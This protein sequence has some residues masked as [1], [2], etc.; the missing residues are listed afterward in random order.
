MTESNS[1]VVMTHGTS[2]GGSKRYA[3]V[4][5]NGYI[6]LQ[7]ERPSIERS[8]SKGCFYVDVKLHCRNVQSRV[9]EDFPFQPSPDGVEFKEW[10][11]LKWSTDGKRKVAY[12]RAVI[13]GNPMSR[14]GWEEA[15]AYIVA[16]KVGGKLADGLKTMAHAGGATWEGDWEAIADYFQGLIEKEME[17]IRPPEVKPTEMLLAAANMKFGVFAEKAIIVAALNASPVNEAADVEG[18]DADDNTFLADDDEEVF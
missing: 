14:N 5:A 12:A 11:G 6:G 2:K 3:L 13:P 16:N 18:D 4:A 10:P 1:N 17:R 7:V 9:A 8:E 15:N